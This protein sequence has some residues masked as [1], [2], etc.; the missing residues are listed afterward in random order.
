MKHLK[1]QLEMVNSKL[2]KLEALGED[3][4][5]MS[6]AH[7]ENVKNDL[8]VQI[9]K[10]EKSKNVKTKDVIIHGYVDQLID[11]TDGKFDGFSSSWFKV[12]AAWAEKMAKTYD[13]ESLDEFFE[14]YTYDH[15]IGWLDAAID[16]GVLLGCGTGDMRVPEEQDSV[17][18]ICNDNSTYEDCLTIGNTYDVTRDIH[19]MYHLYDDNGVPLQTM[20]NRF[21]EVEI[22]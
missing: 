11:N 7:W 16:E 2:A 5:P 6:V 17:L 4:N 13:F 15:T 10:S 18:M 9:Q 1:E 14:E 22:I 19:G 21:V 3:A 20:I 8:V 12:P